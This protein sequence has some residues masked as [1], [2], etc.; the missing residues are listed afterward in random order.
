MDF[1][2][3]PKVIEAR[4]RLRAF[5]DAYVYPREAEHD[6]FVNDPANLWRQPPM[7]EELKAQAR[8]ESLWNWFLPPEYGE[9][10]GG[11]HNLEFAPLAEEMGRL[12]WSFEIFNCSAPDRGNMEVLARYGTPEQQDRWL[13]PLLEG[14]IRSCYAMTEPQVASSDATNI[15]LTIRRDGDHYVLDGRKW[16]ASNI[17]HPLC[18]VLLVMGVSSPDGLRHQRHSTILVPKDTPGLEIVRPMQAFGDFD[19]PGGHGELAFHGVRVPIDNMILGE[20]RGFEIAQGRLGPGRFQYAMTN[21]GMAQRC[22]ELMCARAEERVAFGQKL[23]D[24]SSVRQDIARSRCEIEQARLLVLK[25]AAEM[26]RAGAKGARDY[27]SMVKIIGP[28]LAENVAQRAIQVFG[29][30]GVSQDTPMASMWKLARIM[31]IADG[32][33][34]VH[35]SQLAKLTIRQL[36]G[37]P[38]PA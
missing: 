14:R 23:S 8:A 17:F 36:A 16:Y 21:V 29:A 34:E 15:T 2:H 33:D 35:M 5:M 22:L 24:Q 10:S 6:D 37:A 7:I 13:R 12:P 19:S 4:D 11:F 1:E 38:A 31:R 18:E 26:D 25:A 32:P 9:Y 3:S 28:A 30:K 20:G 27:I